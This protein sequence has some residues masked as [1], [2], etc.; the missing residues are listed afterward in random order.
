MTFRILN[1]LTYH[2]TPWLTTRRRT[3]PICKG[4]VVR[5][6]QAG[7]TALAPPTVLP[8]NQDRSTSSDI[9]AQAAETTN[10]SPTAAIPIPCNDDL[11]RGDDM[12]AT[13]VNDQA[14]ASAPQGGWRGLASMSLSAFSG[15][16]AWREAQR[17]DRDR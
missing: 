16:A 14:E 15:E 11:E 6:L 2:S 3:C 9:Q 4:D 5:S 12:A 17:E 8:P 7:S 1:V 10:E 13:L